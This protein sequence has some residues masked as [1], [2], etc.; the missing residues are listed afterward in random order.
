MDARRRA[1]GPFFAYITPNAAHTPLQCPEGYARRH[2]G[3]VPEDVA[4]FYG[5]IENIDDNF[6]RLVAALEAWG[7]EDETLVIFLTDNGGTLGVPIFNAGLRG[8]KV[9]PYE[10]GTRVPS[11]WRWPAAIQG[12]RDV[13]A[14]AAHVDVFPTLV[15]ALGLAVAAPTRAQIEGRS[16]APFF[17]DGPV[18]WP[19]RTLVTHVGRWPRGQAEASKFRGVS[20]RDDRFAL[21][22]D[23]ELYDLAADPGQARDVI[24]EHPEAAA[25][26]RAEY[27]AWWRSIVPHLENEDAVGPAV[28]PYKEW[29]WRQFGGGPDAGPRPPQREG[30][31]GQP[32]GGAGTSAGVGGAT[33]KRS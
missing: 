11:F 23:A 2:A 6:G 17:R 5:M 10:G 25:R 14:L 7:I 19:R 3:Q 16:I 27:E 8:G 26:L 30:G 9:T 33:G 28:N 24:A 31:E 4:R 13:P 18:A 1:G 15:E 29:Y 12:G 22:N 20:I 21:V 32:T